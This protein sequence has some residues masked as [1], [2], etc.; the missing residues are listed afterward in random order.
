LDLAFGA[1]FRRCKT[2]DKP[3]Y[4]RFRARARFDSVRWPDT[5]GWALK[6][7]RLYVQGIGH[8]SYRTSR[9][10]IRGTPKTLIVKREGRRFFAILQCELARPEPLAPTGRD[11]GLDLGVR[12]LVATS[13]GDLIDN[14]RQFAASRNRLAREQQALARKVKRSGRRRVQV[15]RVAAAQRK[16]ANQRRDFAHQLSRRLVNDFDLICHEDLRITNM[17]RSASGTIDNPGTRAVMAA[18]PR[19]TSQR[20]ASCGHTEAANRVEAKFRCQACGHADHADINAAINILRAG[21]AR[22]LE[23]REAEDKVA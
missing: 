8:I 14:P 2:G 21:L 9:R 22:R 13:D 17:V 1:F 16:I 5:S 7:T 18:E 10:G 6:G 15:H 12:E 11:I 23:Q 20:C 3:G 19:H 4:P